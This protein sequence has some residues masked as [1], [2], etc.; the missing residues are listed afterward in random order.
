MNKKE[1]KYAVHNVTDKIHTGQLLKTYFKTRRIHKSALARKLNR[2]FSNLVNY[3]NNST[4][5]VAILWEISHALKHNFFEDIA[6]QLPA[7]F[8]TDAPIHTHLEEQITTLKTDLQMMTAE[9]DVLLKA[10]G[11]T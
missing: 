7:E 1:K 2:N 4:I 11:R 5:Q 6:C 10:L 8:S 3:Q 9:R